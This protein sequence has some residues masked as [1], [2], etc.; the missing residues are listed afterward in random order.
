MSNTK[1]HLFIASSVDYEKYH[2]DRLISNLREVLFP[3]ELIHFII[4]GCPEESHE[5]LE[6]HIT[7]DRVP[8]RC[9][10]FTPMIFITKNPSRYPFEYGFFAHDTISVGPRFFPYLEEVVA[11]MKS[12]GV[13]TAPIELGQHSMNIG[14]YHR[15]T[16]FANQHDLENLCL[17]T[18][19]TDA[20]WATKN[21]LMYYEDKILY[22]GPLCRKFSEVPVIE[23]VH[24]P[25]GGRHSLRK[26]F[27][28]WD[29]VKLQQNHGF[30]S[31]ISPRSIE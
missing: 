25:D 15:N 1:P 31:S 30:I 27:K 12:G 2:L 16:L 14:V 13:K 10:E 21:K 7:I 28:R 8:Y 23:L 11:S 22:Q 17:Y 26:L 20:L 24:Y 6:D 3:P 29:L 5:E 18:N 9:F 4:G 19:N